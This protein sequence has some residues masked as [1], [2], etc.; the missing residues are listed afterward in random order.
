MHLKRT[1]VSSAHQICVRGSCCWDSFWWCWWVRTDGH[2]YVFYFTCTYVLFYYHTLLRFKKPN[3]SFWI[4]KLMPKTIMN[5]HIFGRS[6]LA[7]L[8]L[9][10]TTDSFESKA[11]SVWRKFSFPFKDFLDR[12]IARSPNRANEFGN[13]DGQEKVSTLTKK[14]DHDGI[15]HRTWNQQKI[16]IWINVPP[17]RMH[18]LLTTGKRIA[19]NTTVDSRHARSVVLRRTPLIDTTQKTY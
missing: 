12:A 8:F 13:Y 4:V 19:L 3:S 5:P 18:L 10:V 17:K 15:P 6:V 11:W 9:V 2:Q 14:N 1:E 7:P 16:C